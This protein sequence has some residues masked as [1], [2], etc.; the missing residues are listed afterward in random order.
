MSAAALERRNARR[1]PFTGRA[2]FEMEG[3]VE[4]LQ[5]RDFSDDGVGAYGLR[6][7]SP[8]QQ[9]MLLVKFSAGS[10]RRYISEV[11]WC[12]SNTDDNAGQY[13]YSL[14]FRILA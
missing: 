9:G 2:F 1:V 5:I 10:I 14:G 4:K 8:G 11:A 3:V 7:C 13:P 12:E 6:G